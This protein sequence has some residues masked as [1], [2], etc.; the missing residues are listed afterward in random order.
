MT[1]FSNLIGM[2]MVLMVLSTMGGQQ[3]I[4]HTKQLCGSV[5]II[6]E[7]A[8]K[9][10]CARRAQRANNR[11]IN[12]VV[13]QCVGQDHTY[14]TIITRRLKNGKYVL[15]ANNRYTCSVTVRVCSSCSHRREPSCIR[16]RMVGRICTCREGFGPKR[17]GNDFV[18][19]RV[20]KSKF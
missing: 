11:R 2:L 3:A 9:K 15:G 5:T 12:N 7:G 18:C 19:R 20:H 1:K 6:G 16:G 8:N 10:D 17:R 14:R 4:A 13:R